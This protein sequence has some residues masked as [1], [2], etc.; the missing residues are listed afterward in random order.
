MAEIAAAA[1]AAAQW[2]VTIHAEDDRNLATIDRS[3]GGRRLG[4]RRRLGR[5]PPSRPA[6]P[7]G[8]R[9]AR[10]LSGLHRI[11][12]RARA[13][14]ASRMVVHGAALGAR[15]RGAWH[16]P[17]APADAPLRRLPAEPRSDR[18]P[19]D[20]RSAASRDRR[21]GVACRQRTAPDV[22]D[23]A[24]AVHG[25][26]VG[27]I[28][29]VPVLHRSRATARSARH[30]RAAARVRGFSGVHRSRGALA[31]PRSAG[32]GARSSGASSIGASANGPEHAQSLALYTDLL[33]LRNTHRALGAA[34]ET[35]IDA[36]AIDDA[37]IAM[38]RE[39]GGE[40]F[41]VVVRLQGAGTSSLPHDE[42]AVPAVVWSTEDARYA[43]DPAPIDVRADGRQI[44]ITFRRPGAVILTY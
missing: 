10:L 38:R 36:A 25:S 14:A 1:R 35:S 7:P 24:A 42:Q 5:R 11:P 37:T 9:Q 39:A 43:S 2:P 28:E 40:R 31:H 27:R 23:D 29:P 26:G 33:R 22:A 44:L 13:H 12:R 8:R 34:E 30:R 17:V 32:C 4:A 16:R 19:G 21:G 15:K 41:M 3:G 18:Q 20:R 6:K